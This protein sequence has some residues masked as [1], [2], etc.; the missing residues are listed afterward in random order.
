M[1]GR[2]VMRTI[3]RSEYA[4]RGQLVGDVAR[5]R[6]TGDPAGSG[7]LFLAN[8]RVLLFAMPGWVPVA[9]KTTNASGE[10][11]FDWLRMGQEFA[12]AADAV[13]QPDGKWAIGDYWDRLF[14]SAMP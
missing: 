5:A 4:G 14:P 3:R 12:A 6:V 11:T 1:S 7:D 2:L 9:E 13:L 10:V 8:E